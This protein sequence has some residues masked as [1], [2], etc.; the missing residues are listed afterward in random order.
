MKHLMTSRLKLREFTPNDLED[1]YAYAS[2]PKVGPPAGWKPHSN[3]QESEKTIQFFIDSQEVWAV[4]LRQE[5]RV[6]G[7]IGLHPDTKRE[8]VRSRMLGYALSSGYWGRGLATE[9]AQRVIRYAFED[10]ELE[11]LSA[12]HYPENVSSQRVIEKC[13]FHYEG[14]LRDAQRLYDGTLR[15]EVCYSILCQEYWQW[16]RR[17]YGI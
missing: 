16:V 6:I 15:D 2:D 17:Y 14:T 5:N 3:R 7:S 13:G 8:H 9:A 11:A 12:I 4:V 1:F 10:L